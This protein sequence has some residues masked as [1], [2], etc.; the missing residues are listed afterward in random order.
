MLSMLKLQLLKN[1]QTKTPPP[2]INKS[3]D[4]D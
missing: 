2:N 1:K 4:F 3:G